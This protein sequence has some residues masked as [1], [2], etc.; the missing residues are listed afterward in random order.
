MYPHANWTLQSRLTRPLFCSA[1]PGALPLAIYMILWCPGQGHS[2]S[3][4]DGRHQR[5]KTIGLVAKDQDQ[6]RTPP[7]RS[8]GNTYGHLQSRG[9]QKSDSRSTPRQHYDLGSRR[10]CGVF[11][12]IANP[13]SACLAELHKTRVAE[14]S[15]AAR[16][17]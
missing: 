13:Q 12:H 16:L 17:A 14:A 6:R 9:L 3:I 2:R 8:V 11:T 15:P 5:P 10:G 1:S 7:C 4:S